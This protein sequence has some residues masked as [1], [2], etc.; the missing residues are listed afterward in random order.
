MI[1]F[2][3]DTA[4][5]EI[6]TLSLHDALPIYLAGAEGRAFDATL[7]ASPALRA[8]E[9][10]LHHEATAR[11]G[12]AL[13]EVWTTEGGA[14]AVP[15]DVRTAASVTAAVWLAAV[16]TL[17]VQHRRLLTSPAGALPGSEIGRAH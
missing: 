4:T 7:E 14:P 5:T 6:Y 9:R 11:L 8:R 17:I 13:Y 16:R 3:N 10:E 12:D 1:F 2:F 15:E